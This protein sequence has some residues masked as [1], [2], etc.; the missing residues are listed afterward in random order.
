[1]RKAWPMEDTA[2]LEPG[3]SEIWVHHLQERP[4]SDTLWSALH[5]RYQKRILVYAHYRLGPDLRRTCDAEDMVNEA[6]IRI[7]THWDQFEYRGPDSLFHWLCLQVRRAI[8][9]RRRQ[10]ER[11]DKGQEGDAN[12]PAL[13]MVRIAA[14]SAPPTSNSQAQTSRSWPFLRFRAL[15]SIAGAWGRQAVSHL[16][17]C[18]GWP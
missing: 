4:D 13:K 18:S 16:F 11:R 3:H 8:L 12:E 5:D 14:V 2:P 1:M 17:T 7:V 6:W 9:D 10:W 15:P